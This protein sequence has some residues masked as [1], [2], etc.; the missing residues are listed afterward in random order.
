MKYPII[1]ITKQN[2]GRILMRPILYQLAFTMLTQELNKFNF[3]DVYNIF[4]RSENIENKNIVLG[5]DFSTFFKP[6]LEQQ[7]GSSIIKRSVTIL[8]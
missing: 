1:L 4:H 7:G 2:V 6:V 5:G 3:F 8:I